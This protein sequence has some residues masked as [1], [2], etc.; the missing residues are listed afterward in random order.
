MTIRWPYA[1]IRKRNPK[2]N[3]PNYPDSSAMFVIRKVPR[4]EAGNMVKGIAR[5]GFRTAA[6]GKGG[7]ERVGQ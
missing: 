4:F 2:K 6:F 5:P 1:D 3:M 7:G